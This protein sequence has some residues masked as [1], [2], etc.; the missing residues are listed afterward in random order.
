VRRDDRRPVAQLSGQNQT[1][2]VVS[3]RRFVAL[4]LEGHQFPGLLLGQQGTQQ[5]VVQ[6]MARL[7]GTEF[8]DDT[9]IAPSSFS[10]R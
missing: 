5:L 8:T 6:G 4:T 7:V 1:V 9:A 10:T 2:V 3:D